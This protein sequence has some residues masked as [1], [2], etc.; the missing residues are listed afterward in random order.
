MELCSLAYDI[1]RFFCRHPL[2]F[3]TCILHTYEMNVTF[4][5][6]AKM[7]KNLHVNKFNC[8]SFTPIEF[9]S[10]IGHVYVEWAT[11]NVC[12]FEENYRF[13]VKFVKLDTLD[14]FVIT[15][16]W[17][18]ANVTAKVEIAFC[19]WDDLTS[20]PIY[21]FFCRANIAS[22]GTRTQIT[23]RMIFGRFM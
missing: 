19:I 11:H 16:P 6:F 10:D 8:H 15:L 9:R 7:F 13:E 4:L 2:H 1:P 21:R 18:S 5:I 23:I 12:I 14:I 20:T 3:T 22:R 17:I